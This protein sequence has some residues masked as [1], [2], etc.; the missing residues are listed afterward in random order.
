MTDIIRSRV[1]RWLDFMDTT[2][3]LWD[4]P[5]DIHTVDHIRR[6]VIL[7]QRLA[8]LRQWSPAQT[9]MIGLAAV[10]HDSRRQDNGLDRGHGRRA[11]EYYRE[12]ARHNLCQYYRQVDHAIAWHDHDDDEGEAA[13]GDDPWGLEVYRVLKDAD[14][15][16]RVRLGDLDTRYLRTEQAHQLVDFATSLFHDPGEVARWS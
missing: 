6:V 16:D 11:A 4:L 10:F 15:L 14:G 9:D 2:V 1:R 7:G 3:T 12:C 8:Y 13:I 5:G